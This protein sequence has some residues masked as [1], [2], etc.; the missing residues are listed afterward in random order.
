MSSVF[1]GAGRLSA[2]VARVLDATGEPV[3]TGFVIGP[4]HIATCA[5]VVTAAAGPEADVTAAR[6]TVDFPLLP[7][8]PRITARVHRWEPVR[9][10][11]RGDIAVLEMDGE[12]LG[13]VAA[14]PLWRADRPWGREFRTVG[15]PAE[16]ADGVWVW[17]EFR[18]PQGIGWMQLHGASGSQPITGGFSGSPVWDAGSEAV[19]GMAVAVD[20]RRL[21]RTAFMIPV[22]E[23]LG[24]DPAL[25]PNP[26]RGLEP[27]GENDSH[28]FY[29]RAA[30]VERVVEALRDQSV[31]AVVGRSGI[32]KSSLV[33]AGVVPQLRADGVR[34]ETLCA[35]TDWLATEPRQGEK[36]LLVADQFEELVAAD[37]KRARTRLR[38][39]LERA[40]DPAVRVL[41]TLRWD[42]MEALSGDDLG[43]ALDRATI[44]LAPMGRE[45]LRRAIRGP[46]AHAPG[47]DIDDDLVER[48]VDDTVGEPGG[49]PLLESVLTELW[50]QR[51]GGRLTV[52]D[53]ER[54]GR[55]AGSIARRA[56]RVYGQFTDAGDARAARR[57]LTKLSAPRG[58]GFARVPLTMREAPELRSVAGRLARERLVVTGRGAGDADVVELAHQSLID[59]WPRLRDWL[60]TDRDFLEWQ[61]RTER[62][63]RTW[64]A[65]PNDDGGLLRGGALSDA[66]EWLARRPDD[67]PDPVRDYVFAGLRV[68]RREVRRWR[69]ITAVLAVVTLVAAGTAVL[70][71]RTGAQRAQA[72]R[73]LA[74][75][76]LA[77]QSLKLAGSQP[78]L[79]L[80]YAQAA[81]RLAPPGDHTVE[82]ALL[83]QQIRLASAES[84]R[85]GLGRDVRLVAADD[86]ATVV[87]TG[88]IDGTVTVWPGLLDGG[89]EPWR[90]PVRDTVALE[91]SGDGR[92][93]AIVD[94]L[95]GVQVWDVAGRSGPFAVR[96]PA[97]GETLTA[98]AV[99]FS[100]DGALLVVSYDTRRSVRPVGHRY[101]LPA[102]QG[103]PDTVDIF[104]TAGDSPAR[105][106]GYKSDTR[107][108]LFPLHVDSST[109]ETWFHV[110]GEDGRQR[111]ELRTADGRRVELRAGDEARGVVVPCADG[112][113]GDVVLRRPTGTKSIGKGTGC[114]AVPEGATLNRDE[115]GRY[116]I[117]SFAPENTLFQLVHLVDIV[118]QQQYRVQAR[119]QAIGKPRWIVRPGPSGPV[120]FVVGADDV[121]RHAAAA[122]FDPSI[123]FGAAPTVMTW[124]RDWRYEAELQS[125]I[126]R[127]ELREVY[128]R[129]R[130]PVS[131]KVPPGSKI[132]ELTIT[133]DNRFLVLAAVDSHELLVYSVPDL[134]PVNRITLPLPVEYQNG[135]VKLPKMSVVAVRD[136]VVAAMHAG[137]ITRWHAATGLPDGAPQ[138]VWRDRDE[139]AVVVEQA[140]A[141]ENGTAPDELLIF[142]PR[143]VTVWD[144][145]AARPVRRMSGA[146]TGLIDAAN[147]TLDIPA[148][149]VWN[150]R[151]RVEVWDTA[152]GEITPALVHIPWAPLVER[153]TT[154]L[155]IVGWDTGEIKI[156]DVEQGTLVDGMLPGADI[157]PWVGRPGRSGMIIT[158][159]GVFTLNLDREN[160]LARL[161][162]ISDREFTAAERELLP[163]GATTDPPCR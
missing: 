147:K 130:P 74:G 87:A 90:L 104:D 46:A 54:V 148:M 146:D 17:G 73:E 2:A 36:L 13:E 11:G 59:N 83:T 16:L 163:L 45:Q 63:R 132:I 98:I 96:S 156:M 41:L 57:L 125:D 121:T 19:V 67:I 88:D 62:E 37:P 25:L 1:P 140:W 42:V 15:F 101:R 64:A 111:Y 47:V 20:R 107:V 154:G 34:I 23:V 35:D 65:Q 92:K 138:Q 137:Y 145:A 155:V 6:V 152:T 124:G 143:A 157:R 75:I 89:A 69:V 116:A 123:G 58:D 133:A 120:L 61:R 38:D 153:T 78:N 128:P 113:L 77:E 9:V 136:D 112:Q 39:M 70:A 10:D 7:D 99:R 28:L 56:E 85:T 14:P 24:L 141:W 93:L 160:I 115:T 91:L 18:A 29:G 3:G 50:E 60:V 162:A 82:A 95:G 12:V 144:S 119:Y 117:L 51:D 100:E 131:V 31:V 97:G 66:E 103:D 48:L 127:L 161:C 150:E 40:E 129:V 135:A 49:L 94:N 21:T 68:R 122:E 43:H 102:D 76:V 126:G 81:A 55:A 5:Q 30:D 71:Y 84:V 105:L 22:N 159:S 53:Y 108:D 158:S 114:L 151:R 118:T 109:G 80:Q 52:A 79:A 33:M 86:T 142:M 139:F 149:Y 110:V 72:L 106:T 44:T 26:Y 32:G 8:A 27:F 134:R 4:G